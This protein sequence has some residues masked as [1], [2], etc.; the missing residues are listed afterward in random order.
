MHLSITSTI[1]NLTRTLS[2]SQC[3]IV[4]VNS[5]GG[6]TFFAIS[7]ELLL[8]AIVE[9]AHS[10]GDEEVKEVTGLT[11][12]AV[13]GCAVGRFITT[14]KLLFERERDELERSF[15]VNSPEFLAFAQDP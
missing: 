5:V 10:V 13:A 2:I 11:F 8:A 1:V 14:A 7:V 15:S 6:D 3:E 12:V 4:V 9:N